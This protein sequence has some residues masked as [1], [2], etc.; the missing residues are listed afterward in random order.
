MISKK[1]ILEKIKDILKDEIMVQVSK[2][3]ITDN[4]S[5][6]KDIGLDS[7]QILEL[8]IALENEFNIRIDDEDLNYEIFSC[9]KSLTDYI[10][11]KVKC[12]R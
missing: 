10:A 4:A 12:G 1:E 2:K 5:L 6:V 8:I 9:V 11:K 7:I 3:E